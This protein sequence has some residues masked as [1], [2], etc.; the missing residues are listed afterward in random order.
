MY[1][2]LFTANPHDFVLD[3]KSR[4]L[5]RFFFASYAQLL[6]VLSAVLHKLMQ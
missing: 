2:L 3:L 5:G 1:K 6:R 4:S